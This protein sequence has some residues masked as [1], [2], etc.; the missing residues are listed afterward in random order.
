MLVLYC[1]GGYRSAL[2]ADAIQKMGYTKVS[3]SGRRLAGDRNSGLPR[4]RSIVQDHGSAIPDDD[5]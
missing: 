3:V 1:G 5:R 2:A 4:R